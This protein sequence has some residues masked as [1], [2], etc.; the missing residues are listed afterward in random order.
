MPAEI[1]IPPSISKVFLIK[2]VVEKNRVG[3][4]IILFSLISL[5]KKESSPWNE[6][7]TLG[8]KNRKR[9]ENPPEKCSLPKILITVNEAP[10][11]FIIGVNAFVNFEYSTR[12]PS[13]DSSDI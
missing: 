1:R 8:E 4:L 13:I 11:L 7:R 10:K 6:A 12:V 2:N 3:S 5:L 9:L